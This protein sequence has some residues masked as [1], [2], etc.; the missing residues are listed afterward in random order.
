MN[1]TPQLSILANGLRFL[2]V[3]VPHAQ[4][5]YVS[6]A[7]MVGRRAEEDNEV[8]AA[9]F[10]EH[11][12]FD[13]TKK[14]PSSLEVNRYIESIGALHNA[15]TWLETVD[16]FAKATAENADGVCD[17]IA[18]IFQNSRLT[19]IDKERKVIAQEAAFKRDDPVQSLRRSRYG[20][21]YSNQRMGRTIFDEDINLPNMTEDVIRNYHE[22]TYVA[23]N[24]LL[25]ITGA[26]S[27]QEATALANKYFASIKRGT[28]TPF[29]SATIT[30]EK[31][32][33]IDQQDVEQSKVALSYASF[34]LGDPRAVPAELLSFILGRGLSSIITF[35]DEE[36]LQEAVNEIA[37]QL[38]LIVREAVTEQELQRAKTM[39]L[40]RLQFAAEDVMQLGDMYVT[41][42]LLT[43]K[44]KDVASQIQ[45]IK[46]V[47]AADILAVARTIFADPPK[48][49][50]ITKTLS[51]LD[52]PDIR[53]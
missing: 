24:F 50:V 4:S 6:L 23:E 29:V 18:D 42:Q 32:I 35:M 15:S 43:G 16:Y 51:T 5:V 10:L 41:Q 48:V 47:T 13:G 31:K 17:F 2:Y 1:T 53:I 8:G 14:R 34:A 7:G 40:S 19:D 3:P 9:H 25:S 20:L 27:A 37:V 26:L 44:T 12:F 46:A 38:Q 22:R 30:K 21:L 33:V 39:L 28:P 11:L 36:K 49:N 52:V 45:E